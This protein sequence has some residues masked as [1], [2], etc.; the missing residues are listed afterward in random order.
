M[1]TNIFKILFISAIFFVAFQVEAY[2]CSFG[3]DMGPGSRGEDVR[4]MQQYL[5]DSGYGNRFSRYGTP[6]GIFGPLTSQ[7]LI[8]WQVSNGLPPI[9]LFE[10]LSRA[11]YYEL[12]QLPTP[13]PIPYPNPTPIPY[14]PVSTDEQRAIDRI[15]DA[16]EM[17]ENAEEEIDDSNMNTALA[18][19]ILEEAEDDM[20]EAMRA[21][22]INRN[23]SR[24]Y[25]RAHDAFRNA[26]DAFEE[27]G[28]D[29]DSDSARDAIEDAEDAIDDAR[30][31]IEDADDDGAYVRDAEDFLDDAEDLLDDAWI[32][33][34]RGD[35]D[36]AE[37]FAKDAEDRAEDAIQ[38]IDW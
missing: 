8:S 35:Y 12:I 9:G 14:P 18:K 28:G 29:S 38:A 21:F 31:A 22:F 5:G 25:D 36:D 34:N 4:C 17:I 2:T 27:A 11:K 16:L 24:A 26:E 15:K 30:D 3:R 32:E 19:E 33:F 6:D 7:A 37:D 23:F 13:Y 1:K 10:S 20:L